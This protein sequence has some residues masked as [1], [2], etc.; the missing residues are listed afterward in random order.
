MIR[1]L[2]S[3]PSV[4]FTRSAVPYR[5]IDGTLIANDWADLTDGTI[6]HDLDLTEIGTKY[7]EFVF[8][9]QRLRHG[10]F[11]VLLRAMT[12]ARAGFGAGER[13][14]EGCDALGLEA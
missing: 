8:L 9:L 10:D 12:S 11:A 6:A 1:A 7:S 3:S 13:D 5:L 2:A 4:R 14:A